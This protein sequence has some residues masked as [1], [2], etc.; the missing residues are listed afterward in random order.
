M[1]F[2]RVSR[3]EFISFKIPALVSALSG[4]SQKFSNWQIGLV[5]NTKEKWSVDGKRF[6]LCFNEVNVHATW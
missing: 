1:S 2:H 4:L 6:L 5:E 3:I